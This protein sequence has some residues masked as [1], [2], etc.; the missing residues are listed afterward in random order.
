MK[1]K[2]IIISAAI[3]SISILVLAYSLGRVAVE[4][5]GARKESS[6]LVDRLEKLSS[7]V[8]KMAEE[9]G[10]QA[11]RSAVN[12]ALDEAVGEPLRWLSEITKASFQTDSKVQEAE[13]PANDT[14][15]GEAIRL[16]RAPIFHV[17]FVE[18]SVTIEITTDVDPSAIMRL[19]TNGDS[20]KHGNPAIQPESS[21]DAEPE[22]S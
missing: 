8:P 6:V 17:E 12:G 9:A 4:V 19:R 14:E 10:D 2:H 20:G 18:P 1:S 7:E 5:A 15:S 22:T 13:R 21:D 3:V 16:P 11:G